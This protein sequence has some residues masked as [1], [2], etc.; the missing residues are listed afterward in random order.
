[1]DRVLDLERVARVIEAADPDI[2]I[3]NEVDQGTERA[4]GVFQADS[5]GSRLNMYATFARSIDYDGGEYGNT[6]LSKYP[7]IDFQIVDLSTDSL[8]EGRSIFISQ[9]GMNEDTLIVMGTHLGLNPDERGLQ[10]DRIIDALPKEG[11]YILAGDFN[12]E[13]TSENYNRLTKYLVDGLS[14]VQNPP[15]MTFPSDNPARRIDFIF[16]SGSIEVLDQADF[17]HDETPT[18]SDHLPLLLHFR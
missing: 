18:A 5:L 14:K 10:I 12:F 17:H 2:I 16:V 9:I 15:A 7:I 13:S 6:L 1:M 3:L 8:L 4:F 11:K